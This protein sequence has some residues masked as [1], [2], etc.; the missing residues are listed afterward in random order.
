MGLNVDLLDKSVSLIH[1]IK[2]SRIADY[3]SDRCLV[4]YTYI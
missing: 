1:N 3:F 2:K 4:L